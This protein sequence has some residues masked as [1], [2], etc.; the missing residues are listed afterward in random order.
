LE[1][2]GVVAELLGRIAPAHLEDPGVAAAVV[3][4][5]H[6]LERVIGTAATAG[7]A[8]ERVTGA[9]D[10]LFALLDAKLGGTP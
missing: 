3:G 5:K 9:T 8:A 2:A 4:L 6:H 1:R 7:R 10:D